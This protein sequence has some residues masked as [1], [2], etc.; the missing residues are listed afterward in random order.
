MQLFRSP[1][2]QETARPVV[3]SYRD[4]A[5]GTTRYGRR[6]VARRQAASVTQEARIVAAR[7]FSTETAN[8]YVI[9]CYDRAA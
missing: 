1:M 4:R 8:D 2:F 6:S 9:V 7:E 3:A 5:Y